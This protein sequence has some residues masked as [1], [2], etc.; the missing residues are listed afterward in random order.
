MFKL[1]FYRQSIASM[2]LLLGVLL[3]L[4]SHDS[5][6]SANQSNDETELKIALALSDVIRASRTEIAS[7][8]SR[9]NDPEIGDK[10]LG[11]DV[12][13]SNILTR[14]KNDKGFDPS[15]S[16]PDSLE[17]HLLRAQLASIQEIADENQTLINKQ[18]VGFKG[19]VPAVFAQM[20]NERF[21]AKVGEDAELKVTAPMHLVRNRK[22]RPDQ[23]ERTVIEDRFSSEKWVAGELF[24]EESEDTGG[25]AFRVMVPEYYGEACLACH[26][27]P[28]G[29]M[30]I[31]GHPKEGGALGDL[32]GAI[33]ITLYR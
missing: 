4:T 28:K 29:E 1:L 23:W 20:I 32:G 15:A 19:F 17:G 27:N 7:L 22:A 9:I 3:A 5:V 16:D 6:V 12:I 8:Q 30:D 33:S 31:T 11:G 13:L 2:A 24:A 14:L 25:K 18:G 10:G 21:S 26:G